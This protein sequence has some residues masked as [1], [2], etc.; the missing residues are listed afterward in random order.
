MSG[1]AFK[2]YICYRRFWWAYHLL[3]CVLIW[4]SS[5]IT[6]VTLQ[7]HLINWVNGKHY[8]SG[9]VLMNWKICSEKFASGKL[10]FSRELILEGSVSKVSDIYILIGNQ[11]YLGGIFHF[12]SISQLWS[13]SH[14]E[15]IFPVQYCHF[16][17][18]K[19]L[20]TGRH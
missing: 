7:S 6:R 3:L 20:I 14:L 1:Q 11:V 5:L 8:F 18:Q 10:F 13:G 17:A 19:T 15:T 16:S 2:I 4:Y 9:E 12:W